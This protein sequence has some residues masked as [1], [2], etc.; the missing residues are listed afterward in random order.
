[1]TM[2]NEYNCSSYSC[3]VYRPCYYK[4]AWKVCW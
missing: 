3:M 2:I 1:M 4:F